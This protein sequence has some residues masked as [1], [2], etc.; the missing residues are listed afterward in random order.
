[1]AGFALHR[2]RLPHA[3]EIPSSIHDILALKRVSFMRA[4]DSCVASTLDRNAF[5]QAARESRDELLVHYALGAL[6]R[7][8]LAARL[9][10]S[11]VRDII[12]SELSVYKNPPMWSVRVKSTKVI[13][14]VSRQQR[15]IF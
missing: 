1:M 4:I 12:N 6:D 13:N 11:M 7:T 5:E 9:S 8:D 2:S 14:T 10:K 3:E 15:Q